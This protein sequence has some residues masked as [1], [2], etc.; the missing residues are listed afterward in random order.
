MLRIF[1]I[2]LT[3]LLLTLKGQLRYHTQEKPAGGLYL[4]GS[5]AG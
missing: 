1:K 3:I 2:S 4:Q 5:P